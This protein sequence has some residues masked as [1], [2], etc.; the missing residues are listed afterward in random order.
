MRGSG[1]EGHVGNT[2]PSRQYQTW[3]G[4]CSSVSGMLCDALGAVGV[5]PGVELVPWQQSHVLND[6]IIMP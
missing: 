6:I 1:A 5:S 2:S 3:Q 4:R